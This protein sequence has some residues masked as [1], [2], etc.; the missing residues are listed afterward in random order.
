MWMMDKEVYCD[1]LKIQEITMNLLSNAV[2]YTRK[3][4][5]FIL[6]SENFLIKEKAMLY[7]K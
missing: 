4:E 5:K 3:A 6:V 1:V 7:F 2:K